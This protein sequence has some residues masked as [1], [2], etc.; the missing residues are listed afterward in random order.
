M[1]NTLDEMARKLRGHQALSKRK[2]LNARLSLLLPDN[3]SR[4]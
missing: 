1:A 2:A 3:Y 4:H